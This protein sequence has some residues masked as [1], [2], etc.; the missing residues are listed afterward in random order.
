MLQHATDEAL[1]RLLR[2]GHPEAFTVIHDRYRPA[3]LA[4]ARRLLAGSGHDAEDV[5]QDAF[6][7]AHA[8][9]RADER[10]I[11]L[12]AWLYAIVRNRALD[13][14]R[15]PR[16]QR[17]AL[18]EG[19]DAPAALAVQPEERA[20][21]RAELRRL[22]AE[23]DALPVRQRTALV[24]HELEGRPLVELA[25]EL[26]TTVAA[27]KSLLVRARANLTPLAA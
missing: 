14:L 9:L 4:Y 10:E 26:D 6:T 8:A 2:A 13:D 23:I 18:E 12:R 3:L 25:R 15:R 16:L 17:L 20:A 27:S 1:V 11:A 21:R 5:V 24:R 19:L 22:V 7:R